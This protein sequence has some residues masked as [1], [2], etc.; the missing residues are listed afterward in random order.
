MENTMKSG[1]TAIIIVII[2]PFSA[3][4]Q[5]NKNELTR[6][7]DSRI[8]TNSDAM[9][10]LGGWAL[11]NMGTGTYGMITTDGNTR[12]FHEMNLM[13]NSVNLGIAALGYLSARNS[14]TDLTLAETIDELHKMEKILLFNAGLDF[15][16]MA[17]G[18]YLWE[19]GLRKDHSRLEGYGQSMILQGA[20]LFVF[21]VILYAVV[22]NDQK[23]AL[24]LLK[25]IQASP[26]G[27]SWRISF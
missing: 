4:S 20:F 21:D 23:E 10:I 7:N 15:G 25:G 24:R 3:F 1:F 9:L 14:S 22:R 8:Q 13:W 19:R 2:L 6:I 17:A 11:T 12:H 18:A 26:S 5:I 16:Y 27:L